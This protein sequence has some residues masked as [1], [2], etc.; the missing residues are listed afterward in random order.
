MSS[1]N[2]NYSSF[3]ILVNQYVSRLPGEIIKYEFKEG[4]PLEFEIIDI[5]ELYKSKR[6]LLVKPHRTGFY[7]ILWVKKG[8]ASHFIDF[9]PVTLKENTLLFLNKD[10][11][12]MYSPR[13]AFE[14][15]AI[16][17]TGAFFSNTEADVKF[18]KENLL[19]ND[20]FT[21]STVQLSDATSPT[22]ETLLK[23]MEEE[24]RK[25]KDEYQSLI[26]KNLLHS[27]LLHAERE[28]SKQNFAEIK[29]SPDR[30]YLVQFRDLLEKYI[31]SQKQVSFYSSKLSIT[32]KRL[33]LATSN[34]LG[35]TV[36]Q[37][38]DQRVMLEAKR[39]LAHTTDSIKEIGFTLGFEEPTNFIKYFKKHHHT[40]PLEFRDRLLEV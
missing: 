39:L 23:M 9:N 40:T 30:D 1:L 21:A 38:I 26:L 13:G 31:R 3:C 17:F 2:K 4:L 5:P 11:V 8:N 35:M 32:E 22:F 15:T 16:V 12:H 19:F 25:S 28:R 6:D 20:L 10:I 29:K 27:F 18:L 37:V 36:K 14:G 7:H 24:G 33:N 34:L